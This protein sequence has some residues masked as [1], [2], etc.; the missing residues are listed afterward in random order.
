M[1]PHPSSSPT[2]PSLSL[3]YPT[4]VRPTKV[5]LKFPG[6]FRV[7][8]VPTGRGD[9]PREWSGVETCRGDERPSRLDHVSVPQE[10]IPQE[11]SITSSRGSRVQTGGLVG[12][13][14]V[15]RDGVG[16]GSGPSRFL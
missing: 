16:S 5:C 13:V 8:S 15:E 2:G 12:V 11:F 14:G 6:T 10:R 3:S 9:E 1:T 7:S 4:R